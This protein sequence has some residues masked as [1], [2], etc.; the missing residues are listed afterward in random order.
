MLTL[1]EIN[2]EEVRQLWRGSIS[3]NGGKAED[4]KRATP[5]WYVDRFIMSSEVVRG[6]VAAMKDGHLTG[7]I[8]AKWPASDQGEPLI[9]IWE[10]IV[11]K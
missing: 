8:F 1:E 7:E 11:P 3:F 4:I 5:D 10:S 2:A 9:A 6:L